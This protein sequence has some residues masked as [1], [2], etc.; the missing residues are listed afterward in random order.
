MRTITC[1]F[2]FAFACTHL[3][4]QSPGGV[5]TTNLRGWFDASTGVTITGGAVSAWTDRA[6]VGNATQG[7]AGE[8][9]VETTAAINYNTALTFDGTNDNFDL[10]D[11]MNSTVTAVSAYA[12]ASQSATTRDTWGSV[13][14]GQANGPSW[15]G[16]GYGLVALNAGSTLHGFYIRD[17]NTR[18]VSF[19]VTNGV[20]TLMSGVWNGVTANAIQAFKNGSSAGTVAYTPGNVGDAGSTWIGCGDGSATNWCFYGHIAEVAIFNTGL[21]TT[22][23]NQVLSYLAVKYGITMTINYLNSAGTTIYAPTGAYVNNIIGI[24]RDDGSGLTQR[25]SRNADDTVRVYL[26]TLAASNSA[27]AGSFSANLSHVMVGANTGKMCQTT[28]SSAEVPVASGV[29][30][31]LEREWKVTNTNFGGTFSMDFRLNGCATPASVT[32]A[33][34]RLLIDDDGD[35]STGTNNVVAS[36]SSGITITYANPVITVSGI[37][38]A[39]IPSGATRYLTIG[40]AN[41]ATPLPVTLTQFNGSRAGIFNAL[42]WQS[43]SEEQFSHYELESSPDGINFSTITKQEPQAN[44]GGVKTY[45]YSDYNFFEPVTY[46]RLKMV[47]LDG[48]SAFSKVIAVDGIWNNPRIQLFPNPATDRL[49]ILVGE[50]NESK[51]KAEIYNLSGALVVTNEFVL[52][53]TVGEQK[54]EMDLVTL[55]PGGYFLLLKNNQ[56]TILAKEKFLKS[57]H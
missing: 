7:T 17:Y 54:L 5:G 22:N 15:V 47:D 24:A 29:L 39:L 14:N 19:S 43:L 38:T 10:T 27:N 23:N 21:N 53:K 6:G 13:L 36:G 52:S 55:Q 25:Q 12:V 31:R 26:S 33:D 32:V 48:T 37:S 9:P 34:L 20:T 56:G 16:G 1:C 11:R 28:A 42:S 44:D 35:F 3:F 30:R 41:I 18:G 8:R 4:S 50:V 46:Y 40:S 57:K 2:L 51:V 49:N 45:R